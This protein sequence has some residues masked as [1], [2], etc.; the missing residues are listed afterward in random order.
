MKIY[1]LMGGGTFMTAAMCDELFYS[2][3]TMATDK[4]SRRNIKLPE[5][6]GQIVTDFS[7]V[8]WNEFYGMRFTAELETDLGTRRVTYIVRTR[9]L[10]G[11]EDSVWVFLRRREEECPA[12][13]MSLN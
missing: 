2:A 5:A 7:T 1:C 11:V 10:E 4:L 8:S 3:L 13:D 9:D 6:E 12:S